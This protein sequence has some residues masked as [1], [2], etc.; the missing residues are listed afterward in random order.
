MDAIALLR[1]EFDWAHELLELVME[2]VDQTQ[3]ATTPPGLANPLGATYAHAV[4]SEDILVNGLLREATPLYLGEWESRTG[5][6]APQLGASFEWARELEVDI[7]QARE[8]A[9]AVYTATNAYLDT[10][11]PID[12]ERELDL[13]DHGFG[14]K[15][16]SWV[17]TALITSHLNNMAG[18]ISVLKGIQGAKGYPF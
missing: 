17:F 14:I 3:A 12:L 9:R 13:S 4:V 8:Y 7:L 6:S 1:Q 18:E 2:D 11:K 10:L 5:I 16:V 15:A